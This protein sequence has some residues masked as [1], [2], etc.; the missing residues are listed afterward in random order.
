[1]STRADGTE[2]SFNHSMKNSFLPTKIGSHKSSRIDLS[3]SIKFN[4]ASC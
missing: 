2:K 3:L 1:M 4:Y